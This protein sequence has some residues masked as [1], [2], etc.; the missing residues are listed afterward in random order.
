MIY[1][2][3][4]ATSFPKPR[5]VA[6]AMSLALQSTGNSGRGAH[7][8]SLAA[9][10]LVF[11]TRA[12]LAEFFGAQD[13]SR[14]SFTANATESLNIALLGLFRPGD[15]VITT[16][17]EHNSVLRPL[18]LLEARGVELSI[19]PS[20]GQGV[21]DLTSLE[22]YLQPNTKAVVCTHA[23]NVTGNL[24]DLDYVSRFCRVHELL[25]IVDGAQTAGLL[26]LDVIRQ[27]ID[28]LCFTGHK[29]LYGPQGIGGI[30][31][32]PGLQL[33]PFKVGG[34]GMQTF[35]KTHPTQMP[36]ALEAGTLNTPGIAGL[37]AGV[38]YIKNI[39]LTQIRHYEQE[40]TWYFYQKVLKLPGIE[41]YGD[42]GSPQ[43]CPIVALNIA[44]LDSSFVSQI[45]SED[46]GIYTRAGA[47]CAPLM[48]HALGTVERGVVRFSFS[49]FNTE[50]ELNKTLQALASIQEKWGRENHD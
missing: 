5:E 22:S 17:W 28:V 10:R 33:S 4:A 8:F 37:L 43:R 42:F 21:L 15:H 38:R 1:L 11:A 39:G 6:D 35:S 36:E 24:L 29:S 13:P 41:V 27:E 7:E 30:Y 49:H 44:G 18:Y 45:L 23:S 16:A 26:P 20:D 14:L 40:L 46:Y 2:D 25:F 31:V 47:H 50:E 12:E 32:R 34:S 9:S 19:L 3:Q 48:H